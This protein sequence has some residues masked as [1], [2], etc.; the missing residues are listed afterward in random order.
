MNNINEEDSKY[1]SNEA[2]DR[3]QVAL[4]QDISMQMKR[5]IKESCKEV[6]KLL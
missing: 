3:E 6:S 4:S 2:S 5:S 1:E